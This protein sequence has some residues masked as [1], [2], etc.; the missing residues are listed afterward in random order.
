MEDEDRELQEKRREKNPS[1]QF[2]IL[3]KEEG[4]LSRVQIILKEGAQGISCQISSQIRK[5][6]QAVLV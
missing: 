3:S 4:W 1:L 5:K 6:K 2:S